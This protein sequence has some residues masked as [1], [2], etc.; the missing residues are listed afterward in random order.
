MNWLMPAKSA[1]L[2][3]SNIL[4]LHAR[5]YRTSW[6]L[7][8]RSFAIC[9]VSPTNKATLRLL[10]YIKSLE[11]I[12]TMWQLSIIDTFASCTESQFEVQ[13]PLSAQQLAIYRFYSL[14][15]QCDRQ[16]YGPWSTR[17]TVPE[18]QDA[19]QI[20]KDHEKYQLLLASPGTGKTQVVKRLINTLI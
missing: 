16:I 6:G 10:Y 14:V 9:L 13:Y 20:H 18:N 2:S 11:D 19:S 5:S 15:Q 12:Y 4:C 17:G 1:L 3:S 8:M 7:G